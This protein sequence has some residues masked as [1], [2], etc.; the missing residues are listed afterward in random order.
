MVTR[1]F[2]PGSE[3]LYLKIYTGVKTADLILQEAIIP[4]VNFLLKEEQ[5]IIKWFIIRYNDP[6][7]HLRIRFQLTDANNYK[8]VLG[9][10]NYHLKDFIDS[11]EIANIMIDSYKRELERYGENTIE[12]AEELFYKSSELILKFLEYDDDEKIIVSMFYIDK[13]FSALRLSENEKW[14]WISKFNN[15]YKKEFNA[16]KN[17][18]T[19]LDIKFRKFK[20]GY[21]DF[22]ESDEYA[23]IRNIITSSIDENIISQCNQNRLT[24]ISLSDFFQ[25]IFHMHINRTFISDQRLFEMIIYDYSNRYYKALINNKKYSGEIR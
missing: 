15:S 6:K 3:W 20:P 25:S 18:N 8:V 16:D 5:L 9:K 10:V 13:I 17:L 12:L 2:L 4:L 21:L 11:G 22:V 24:P 1:K 7:P 23:E 19:Q 14:A